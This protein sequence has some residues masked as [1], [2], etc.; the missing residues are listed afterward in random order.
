MFRKSYSEKSLKLFTGK[1]IEMNEDPYWYFPDDVPTQQEIQLDGLGSLF[2]EKRK[3]KL[4][5]A[6]QRAAFS[7]AVIIVM[8]ETCF[9]GNDKDF[10]TFLEKGIINA[11]GKKTAKIVEKGFDSIYD[12]QDF[13]VYGR[14]WA[15]SKL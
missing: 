12:F 1:L 3:E 10:S 14:K 4:T 13:G 15:L 8:A 5:L 2:G 9:D 11:F 7:S 6:K